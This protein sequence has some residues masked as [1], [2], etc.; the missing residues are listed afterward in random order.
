[1]NKKR[2]KS[3]KSP[4][5]QPRTSS[6]GQC[7]PNILDVPDWIDWDCDDYPL[8][9]VSDGYHKSYRKITNLLGGTR[10]G[11]D[12]GSKNLKWLSY[13]RTEGNKASKSVKGPVYEEVPRYLWG[14]DTK[15][16]KLKISKNDGILGETSKKDPSKTCSKGK[17]C[18][19]ENS[20]EDKCVYQWKGDSRGIPRANC[21]GKD[22]NKFN[23]P[24]TSSRDKWKYSYDNSNKIC[25]NNCI[26][27]NCNEE[28]E[29]SCKLQCD[30]DCRDG[31]KSC[32][33]ECYHQCDKDCFDNCI[34]NC[35][36]SY[37]SGIGTF[38]NG[39]FCF[40]AKFDG[41]LFDTYENVKDFIGCDC[42]ERTIDTGFECVN[43]GTKECSELEYDGGPEWKFIDEAAA[44]ACCSLEEHEVSAYP[45]CQYAFDPNSPTSKCPAL[46]Q[47]FCQ[48]HWGNSDEIGEKCDQFLQDSNSNVRAIKLTIQNYITNPNRV[49][50]DYISRDLLKS[51][52]K[53]SEDYYN[54][55]FCQNT[56][57]SVSNKPSK[58]SSKGFLEKVNSSDKNKVKCNREDSIDPFFTTHIGHLCSFGEKNITAN[59]EKMIG[60]CD[61]QL[62]YFCGQYTRED[63]A[64]DRTLQKICGCHLVGQYNPPND[65]K[66]PCTYPCLD[67]SGNNV[68]NLQGTR[69]TKSPYYDLPDGDNCDVLC[70]SSNI[71][72]GYGK[73][74]SPFC[75]I[76]S[77]SVNVVGS[78]IGGDID[79]SE[80][81]KGSRC[82]IGSTEIN[83]INSDVKGQ[84]QIK[85]DCGSCWVFDSTED[86]VSPTSQSKKVDCGSIQLQ[87]DDNGNGK[88]EEI[89]TDVNYTVYIVIFLVVMMIIAFGLY[90]L[91]K[92]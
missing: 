12:L 75:I 48:N 68:W 30:T 64:Q 5:N 43:V 37:S 33:E 19:S 44:V 46:M 11:E 26:E 54:D 50:Q 89:E 13:F 32:Q 4:S 86:Q 56:P 85:Q 38:S 31:D 9:D 20:T 28:G 1:M 88:K 55:K 2:N 25:R 17:T 66:K 8:S 10:E 36:K 83:I 82:Y 15:T 67:S 39:S 70:T 73:C 7:D 14:L 23:G 92:R 40:N 29:N 87:P 81:C 22:T 74:T 63:L 18:C 51:G 34:A 3:S 16:Q 45:Q 71:Q 60:V 42:K 58:S 61:E 6:G 59:Q 65:T 90:Y 72:N 52:H 77:V 69:Q 91:M 41:I 84:A 79:I 47:E 80:A 57:E 53:P 27:D 78:E 21:D 24:Q 35:N 76:D 62:N 49:P